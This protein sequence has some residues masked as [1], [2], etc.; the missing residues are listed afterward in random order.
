MVMRESGGPDYNP[1]IFKLAETNGVKLNS[2][3][4]ILFLNQAAASDSTVLKLISN[5]EA[6][7]FAGGDQGNYIRCVNKGRRGMRTSCAL[8]PFIL[9]LPFDLGPSVPWPLRLWLY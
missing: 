7:F 6:I 8:S 4:T 9:L 3:T 5:A 1:W 2:V